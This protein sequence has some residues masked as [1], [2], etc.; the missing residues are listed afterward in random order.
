MIF[1]GTPEPAKKILQA[2]VDA[3]HEIICV[4]TQPDRKCGRGQKVAQSMVAQLANRLGLPCE[5]P[6]K[7]KDKVFISLLNSLRPDL[8]IIVAYGKILPKDILVIPKFGC[9]NVHA[10][11]LPKLRGAA[12]VQWA[13]LNGEK[14]TGVT[15]MQL[16]VGLDTGPILAQEKV[17]IAAEDTATALTEK[18]FA[19]GAKLLIKMLPKIAD[20]KISSV[21]QDNLSA[22]YAPA[23]RKEEGLLD[24]KKPAKQI[25]NRVRAFDPWPGA[26]TFYRKKMLKFFRVSSEFVELRKSFAPG[27]VVDIIKGRGFVVAAQ[28]CGLRVEEVQGE[29]GRRMGAYEFVIGHG[30]KVG[31]V[32]PL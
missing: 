1:M 26:F 18:L 5:K 28:D 14:E 30:I 23:L 12:P 3:R 17:A 2:L 6:E 31:D 8:I 21:P 13:I 10:S 32:L 25:R 15:V 24:F 7:I 20:G 29:A 9:I 4:V 19:V 27:E 11:L 22:T 16:D